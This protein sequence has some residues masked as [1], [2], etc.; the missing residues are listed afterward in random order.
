[1]IRRV[2][3]FLILGA[4]MAIPGVASPAKKDLPVPTAGA[5]HYWTCQDADCG[6]SED[7]VVGSFSFVGGLS[8]DGGSY[9]GTF[10]VD[11]VAHRVC[12]ALPSSG[13]RLRID[14]ASVFRREYSVNVDF[15]VDFFCTG[16]DIPAFG[17]AIGGSCDG[18][19]QLGDVARLTCSFNTGTGLSGTRTLL[20]VAAE[21]LY[22]LP[23]DIFCDG[24][25]RTTTS[26]VGV[27]TPGDLNSV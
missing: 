17:P 27:Y 23:C 1:M 5:A 15:C 25:P 26:Y 16:A 12:P 10:G 9:Q 7:T 13:C 22:N 6:N 8:L 21:E 3:V 2:A 19:I 20:V 14:S 4:L 11:F 18:G 24:P